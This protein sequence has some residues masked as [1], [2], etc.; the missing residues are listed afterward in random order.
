MKEELLVAGI[1]EA[2]YGPRLGPL[3]VTLSAFRTD[4]GPL[5]RALAAAV[6]KNAAI[7]EP[8]LR[9]DDSKVVYRGRNGFACLEKTVLGFWFAAAGRL[10]AD[11][12]DLLE[13]S[14]QAGLDLSGCPWYGPVP[15]AAPLPLAVKPQIAV[16]SG[17]L[18]KGTCRR[19][20]VR[21]HGFKTR[22]VPEPHFNRGVTRH[23]NKARLLAD[24]VLDLIIS[25][26]SECPETDMQVFVDKLGGR[27][28]Y[29]E[30]L[31]QR[32]PGRSLSVIKESRAL[33]SYR[34]KED[35]RTI[36]IDFVRSGDKRHMPVALSSMFCKYV[37][38]VFMKL[39]NQYWI[40]LDPEIRPTAGYPKDAERFLEEV[41]EA[42]A[43][44]GIS[45]ESLVRR[46]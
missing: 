34:L 29:A 45:M 6:T 11:L 27:N 38:E 16:K 42:A 28:C 3:T 26:A 4:A 8:L 12:G 46:R 15:L 32:S 9:V 13:G 20:G 5:D 35:A 36:S 10:P 41:G 33:S 24:R 40:K 44:A 31:A 1:D 18:L 37:R 23:G 22:I 21:F 25:A 17:R 43:H 14:G 19:E 2:G 39:F 7:D 30:I